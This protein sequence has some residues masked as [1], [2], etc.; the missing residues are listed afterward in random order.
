MLPRVGSAPCQ[1]VAIHTLVPLMKELYLGFVLL[2]RIQKRQSHFGR[3]WQGKDSKQTTGDRPRSGKK[4]RPSSAGKVSTASTKGLDASIDLTDARDEVDRTA[5]QGE[6]V[7]T[8]Q[9][10]SRFT[11]G[12]SNI[13]ISMQSLLSRGNR[14]ASSF[15]D[16]AYNSDLP[17]P[18]SVL[19]EAALEEVGAAL[20]NHSQEEASE[21]AER[22]RVVAEA[23]M[24]VGDDDSDDTPETRKRK[25]TMTSGIMSS[26]STGMGLDSHRTWTPGKTSEHEEGED[27]EDSQANTATREFNRLDTDE[28]NMSPPEDP[29]S[30]T[31][32]LRHAL[33]KRQASLATNILLGSPTSDDNIAPEIPFMQIGGAAV[34]AQADS[35]H[36]DNAEM[37]QEHGSL[38]S[39]LFGGSVTGSRELQWDNAEPATLSFR[40]KSLE[41]LSTT[42][43]PGT[44]SDQLFDKLKTRLFADSEPSDVPMSSGGLEAA[45]RGASSMEY[46][47]SQRETC[48]SSSTHLVTASKS[49]QGLAA[50]LFNAS[51]ME[52]LAGQRE[53]QDHAPSSADAQGTQIYDGKNASTSLDQIAHAVESDV[54]AS[55]HREGSG[56]NDESTAPSRDGTANEAMDDDTRSEIDRLLVIRPAATTVYVGDDMLPQSRTSTSLTPSTGTLDTIDEGENEPDEKEQLPEDKYR[57]QL[58]TLQQRASQGG[59]DDTGESSRRLSQSSSL[60]ALVESDVGEDD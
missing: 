40:A 48:E 1:P 52:H 49:E 55:S 33:E 26:V 30:A 51:S 39:A 47:A 28:S 11:T 35:K 2:S 50:A 24:V 56:N 57:Y 17:S 37:H 58:A 42:R 9:R 43:G 60:P 53:S 18:D 32:M 10:R 20:E 4:D 38:E 21:D 22:L 54:A 41:Q 27:V 34:S 44:G 13:A 7:T 8:A 14:Q 19:N 5:E 3:F 45:L 23:V 59:G 6:A 15:S 12:L 25:M 29:P 36:P 31:T 16:P 46:I